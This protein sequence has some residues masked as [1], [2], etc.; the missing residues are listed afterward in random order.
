MLVDLR[1]DTV[2]APSPGM[3]EAMATAPVGDDVYGEDPTV[4]ELEHTIAQLL[5]HDAGLFCPTGSLA[6]WLA[7]KVLVADGQEVLCDADSHI[8]RAELGA[9]GTLGTLTTRTWP[10]TARPG[11]V[12]GV[13]DADIV[14]SM[15]AAQSNPYL[16]GTAAIAL[17]NTHNFAG[18]AIQPLDHL[19]TLHHFASKH[20]IH[21]HLDGARLW[22]ACTATGHSPKQ[23]AQLTTTTTVCLSKGLGAP[24]GSVLVGPKDTIAQARVWRK[25]AG[26]GMRQ[27]GLLAAAGLYALQHHLPDLH[28]D[29]QHAQQ[30]AASA[31]HAAPNSVPHPPHT[32]IVLVNVPN[33]QTTV[34][35]LRTHNVLALALTPTTVRLITHRDLST[36]HITHAC[37]AL[38]HVLGT[39]GNTTDE[40]SGTSQT[41]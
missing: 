32:N 27:V 5:G 7:L 26:A 39:P 12:P 11:A 15:V 3:R 36:Q 20:N 10:S 34:D 28:L 19:Q 21:I 35:A 40:A 1:S 38:Q 41:T 2:T 9:H 31:N 8:V 18:G 23:Y 16:V 14:T 22:N 17:E 30:L 33:A 25:R 13:V 29:H 4:T 6:N 24:V 37:T